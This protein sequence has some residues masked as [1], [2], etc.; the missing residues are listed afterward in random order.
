MVGFDIKTIAESLE[1]NIDNVKTDARYQRLLEPARVKRLVASMQEYGI[2]P[3]HIMVNQEMTVIDGQHTLAALREMGERT[4]FV[5]IVRCK[6]ERSEAEF[7]ST[8]NAWSTSLK[9]LD[10]WHAKRKR[11]DETALFV[12]RLAS[13][14]SS[15]LAGRISQ[16]KGVPVTDTPMTVNT[17]LVFV[18]S[19]AAR[20]YEDMKLDEALSAAKKQGKTDVLLREVNRRVDFLFQSFG[21]KSVCPVAWQAKPLKT[22][23]RL[24]DLIDDT[25][26][27]DGDEFRKSVQKMA[28]FP[29]N[30]KHNGYHERQMLSI[31]A[32]HYNKNLTVNKLVLTDA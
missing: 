22:L 1:V 8:T 25:G 13:D 11:G 19:A 5:T 15:L 6:D 4:V 28:K 32:A 12:H 31:L 17:A 24:F 2:W 18:K 14:K 23:M 3:T 7:F 9:P 26:R 21:D 10:L 16:V 29:W 27:L 20:L 30:A